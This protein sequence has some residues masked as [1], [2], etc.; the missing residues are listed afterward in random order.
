[1]A[2]EVVETEV[3]SGP[4]RSRLDSPGRGWTP[5]VEV[6]PPG[7][8][9]WTRGLARLDPPVEVGGLEVGWTQV[10]PRF[11]EVEPRFDEI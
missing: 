10:D 11:D 5:P 2:G 3:G 4:P 6:G 1:M 8:G 9:G 7:R